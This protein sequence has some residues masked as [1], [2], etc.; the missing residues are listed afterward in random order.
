MSL[1][2][3]LSKIP[4]L[5]AGAGSFYPL[6]WPGLT[7]AHTQQRMKWSDPE[8]TGCLPGSPGCYGEAR[9][10]RWGPGPS[11]QLYCFPPSWGRSSSLVQQRGRVLQTPQVTV[12]GPKNAQQGPKG[13]GPGPLMVA[14]VPATFRQFV[15]Q[16]CR[17]ESL[18][19]APP[20]PLPS[21]FY[22]DFTPAPP[23]PHA[24]FWF[25][26]HLVTCEE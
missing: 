13:R 6:G 22:S 23:L 1:G 20:T 11:H 16:N 14:L 18:L 17:A 26:G 7:P 8:P 4:I 10:G 19:P 21:S 5:L 12:D 25:C 2:H 9:L 24:V 15:S 3:C